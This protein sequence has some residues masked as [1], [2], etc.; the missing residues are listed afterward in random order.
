MRS[1]GDTG[2]RLVFISWTKKSGEN[3]EGPQYFLKF[4]RFSNFKCCLWEV[5]NPTEGGG[6]EGKR[7][8]KECLGAKVLVRA[9]EVRPRHS[10]TRRRRTCV[11]EELSTSDKV[12]SLNECNCTDK[13]LRSDKIHKGLIFVR[14]DKGNWILNKNSCLHLHRS[15]FRMHAW[16]K[17][18]SRRGYPPRVRRG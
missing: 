13:G 7:E 10:R 12:L 9:L 18:S 2:R 8:T 1:V 3:E 15:T 6:R 16:P 17:G 14:H 4:G 5:A 11:H